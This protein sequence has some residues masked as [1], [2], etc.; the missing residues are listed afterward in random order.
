MPP[1]PLV[2]DRAASTC[3]RAAR[4][5]RDAWHAPPCPPAPRPAAR[6]KS[7]G[8]A[9]R[10]PSE[11]TAIA[12]NGS[13]GS[14]ALN[15]MPVTAA[16]ML[17]TRAEGGSGSSP[18]SP[19]GPAAARKRSP[20]SLLSALCESAIGAS[21]S[22]PARSATDAPTTGSEARR[23][24]GPGCRP[25]RVLHLARSWVLP[26]PAF[27]MRTGFRGNERKANGNQA[28][29]TRAHASSTVAHPACGLF[30]WPARHLPFSMALKRRTFLKY[31][32]SSILYRNV[33]SHELTFSLVDAD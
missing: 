18:F 15:S 24:H 7:V 28:P 20:S 10:R 5:A 16:S 22:R 14:C 9:E 30:L 4:A 6:G 13:F 25:R 27:P 1:T 31:P 2:C 29:S 3:R 26:L 12:P 11:N 21:K 33:M 17:N 8:C 32:Q 23:R 19:T